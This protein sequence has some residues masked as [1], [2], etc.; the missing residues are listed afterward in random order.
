MINM[1]ES[2]PDKYDDDKLS[3]KIVTERKER[4]NHS[5]VRSLSEGESEWGENL[6]ICDEIIGSHLFPG[7][8]SPRMPK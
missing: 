2:P 7:G 1:N 3:L 4:N 6:K 5:L 8:T